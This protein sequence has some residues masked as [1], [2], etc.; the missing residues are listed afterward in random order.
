KLDLKAAQQMYQRFVKNEFKDFKVGLIHGQMKR[1]EAEK[2]MKDFQNK[3]IDILV[4][5][6]IL[7]VG[8]DVPN[9]NLMIIEHAERFGLSQLHQ[10]RGRIGRG[11]AKSFCVLMTGGKVSEEAEQRLSAMM[12]TTNGFEI[13]ELDLQLRGPGEFF[14]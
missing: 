12:R 14:G 5:T 9:A 3:R 13:A 10:L 4:S 11:S 1:R 7:E 2:V 6:T 8:V